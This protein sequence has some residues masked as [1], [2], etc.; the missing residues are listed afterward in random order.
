MI[1]HYME[2]TNTKVS[3]EENNGKC[4]KSSFVPENEL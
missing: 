1:C 2:I 3:L 4:L